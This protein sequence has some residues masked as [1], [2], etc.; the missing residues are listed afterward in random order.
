MVQVRPTLIRSDS[1]NIDV[2]QWLDYMKD[3]VHLPVERIET[4]IVML[5][6]TP[7]PSEWQVNLNCLDIGVEMAQI[8]IELE[9][10][11]A[12]VAAALI[13]RAVREEFIALNEVTERLGKDVAELV[14]GTLMMAA[15]SRSR[16]QTSDSDA[17]A[18]LNQKD[19]VR[20]MLVALTDDVRVAL[21]KLA[22]RTCAIRAVKNHVERRRQIA[23]EVSEIYAPLAHRLGIGHIKWELEDLSFRYLKPDE[24]ASVAKQLDER[25]VDRDQFIQAAKRQI[26]EALQ[27]AGVSNA[28]VT[29]RAKHIYSIWRKMQ[30]KDYTFGQLFD[31]RAF[32]ILVDQLADC[33]TALGVIH[34]L[35]NHIPQQFDDYIT[36]PKANGYRSLHTAV[37]GPQAKTMEVQ[38]RTR[39]MHNEAELG[40]CAHWKY[41]GTD[42]ENTK[43]SYESKLEW[44]RQVL[45]WHEEIDD[46]ANSELS[47]VVKAD[48]I[49]VFSKAGHVIDLPVGATALDFAYRIH[50]DVG[51]TCKGAK[52]GG[53]IIPLN[54]A[55]K[56]GDQI[57]ILTKKN[58]R[59]SRDWL[60]SDAGYITTSRARAKIIHWFKNDERDENEAIGRQA[61]DAELKRIGN[62]DIN[63]RKL[64]GLVNYK[65]EAGMC[66]AIGAG[67]L[68]LTQV[69]AAAQRASDRAQKP[70]DVADIRSKLAN[71]QPTV[72][73]KEAVYVG[74]EGGMMSYLASCCSPLPGDNIVGYVTVSRGVGVHRA[75]CTNALRLKETEPARIIAVTWSDNASSTFR[76]DIEI[77]AIE[78][79]GLLRDITALLADEKVDIA[80]LYSTD[81]P[82]AAKY[83]ALTVVV[84]TLDHLGRVLA[85]LIALPGIV[86]AKRKRGV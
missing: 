79:D 38:I 11:E 59:P 85:K 57:E 60:S 76:V 55:L 43:S 2:D 13:Y 9:L 66:A 28:E 22:E 24:Y 78:R 31:I 35:Y 23:I 81:Q 12:S 14:S 74:G 52:V 51:N 86:S 46:G 27:A 40:V 15:I 33:Y 49:Y 39:A 4:A 47:N 21:I 54:Q 41:K 32:R 29:G 44:L 50:S 56:T 48:R 3:S 61:L 36:N 19:N 70:L 65:D 67:D 34:S 64:A 7:M 63:L 25:R 62:S 58:G 69:L 6:Q 82:G 53:K 1:G 72:A 18:H 10:D 75:E 84:P 5:R 37:F 20:K 16:G 30:I 26:E 17:A 71:A 42:V 68:K 8:L 80:A 83:I 77:E 45:D 73:N